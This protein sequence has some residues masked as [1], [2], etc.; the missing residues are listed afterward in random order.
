MRGIPDKTSFTLPSGEVI[1]LFYINVLAEAIGRTPQSVR[2]W[3]LAGVIPRTC[4]NDQY[5]RRLYSQE[6]IDAVVRCIEES[7][8]SSHRRT[9]YKFSALCTTAFKE[10]QEKYMGG[11]T[12]G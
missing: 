5:N 3:E 12:D 10:L 7:R 6:Q 8:L 9:T 1:D 4:F 11:K 2:K